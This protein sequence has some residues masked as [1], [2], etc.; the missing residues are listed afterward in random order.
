M[1]A[2]CHFDDDVAVDVGHVAVADGLEV[3]AAAGQEQVA[4]EAVAHARKLD[5]ECLAPLEHIAHAQAFLLDEFVVEVELVV[6]VCVHIPSLSVDGS[7]IDVEQVGGAVDVEGAGG[8][9]V[10]GIVLLLLLVAIAG[11]GHHEHHVLPAQVLL[12]GGD[13][14]A[15]VLVQTDIGLLQLALPLRGLVVLDIACIVG[16][17]EQV[18]SAVGAH[19][20]VAEALQR[21]VCNARI[22]GDEIV[23]SER[24]GW[25]GLIEH[26]SP[27]GQVLAVIGRSGPFAIFVYPDSSVGSVAGREDGR[28][29]EGCYG[30][31][32]G[33]AFGGYLEFVAN[34]RRH[35]MVGGILEFWVAVAGDGLQ[36][37][38]VEPLLANDTII[39][40]CGSCLNGGNGRCP[41]DGRK[42]VGHVLEYLALLEQLAE[43]FLG[44]ERSEG[45]DIVGAQLVNG[46]VDHKLGRRIERLCLCGSGGDGDE[47]CCNVSIH[48]CPFS[49][50]KPRSGTHFLT[51]KTMPQNTCLRHS[52]GKVLPQR[53][54]LQGQ[55]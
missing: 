17:L 27:F 2:W 49:F 50:C 7:E 5:E 10:F 24:L 16:H 4:R 28:V 55:R 46:D 23:G 42:G 20:R 36:R 13:E 52:P 18:R 48:V 54:V 43:T 12:D 14:L 6:E 8:Y 1:P 22:D 30:I 35:D 33:P 51:T 3:V 25:V 31:D 44:I 37:V 9:A 21:H 15:N 19:G 39:I 47:R 26:L 53:T 38:A 41:V 45:L 11:A 34:G 32:Q 29:A 40:R